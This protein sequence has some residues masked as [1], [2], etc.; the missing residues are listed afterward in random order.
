MGTYFISK[1]VTHVC[2]VVCWGSPRP[3]PAP[4]A[5]VCVTFDSPPVN[6]RMSV[7]LVTPRFAIGCPCQVHQTR[8]NPPVPFYARHNSSSSANVTAWHASQGSCLYRYFWLFNDAIFTMAVTDNVAVPTF[9]RKLQDFS[10]KSRYISTRLH[11]VTSQIKAVR[12]C[13]DWGR[14][15]R[16]SHRFQSQASPC[17]ICGGQCGSGT[18]FTT[19]TVELG[20]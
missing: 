3:P 15:R 5:D 19:S 10:L 7:I 18:G 9:Q 11:G 16:A 6:L 4:S 8:F 12:P 1:K 2:L 13:H 20:Y 14:Y 17:G